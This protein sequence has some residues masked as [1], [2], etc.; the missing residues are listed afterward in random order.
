[1]S[2]TQRH[3]G[4]AGRERRTTALHLPGTERGAANPAL[5]Q[6]PPD[7]RDRLYLCL[8]QGPDAEPL[9]AGR[10]PCVPGK[11]SAARPREPRQTW[12]FDPSAPRPH[13][14]LL[15][16]PGCGAAVMAAGVGTALLATKT[17]QNASCQHRSRAG[18]GQGRLPA[19]I[20]AADNTGVDQINTG[21]RCQLRDRRCP[22]AA[23]VTSDPEGTGPGSRVTVLWLHSNLSSQRP[24]ASG[25]QAPASQEG[26]EPVSRIK[27]S[28]SAGER[29]RPPHRALG[30]TVHCVQPVFSACLK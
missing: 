16:L 12:R 27:A 28:K 30:Y 6:G 17:R 29:E 2:S 18:A 3:P 19:W 8:R 20:L 5:W 26:N 21:V 15:L 4:T 23:A 14:L 10:P 13:R 25:E 7:P 1:M 9:W 22:G 11:Q 24:A